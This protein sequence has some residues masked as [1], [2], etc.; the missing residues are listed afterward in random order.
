MRC[1]VRKG[2][3]KNFAKF[4]GNHLC[5][6]LWHR[7]F[8]VNFAKFLRTPFLQNTSGHLLLAFYT[9]ILNISQRQAVSKLIEKK[10]NDKRYLKNWRP[11]SLLNVDTKIFSKA[12]SNKLKAVLPTLISSQQTAHVK[13][14]F[15][16]E[17]NR[18]IPDIIEISG[19]LN[20]E[21]F[22]V[23]MDIEKTFDSLDHDFLSSVLRKFGFGKNFIAWIEIL[24]KDQL[25]CIING[26]TTT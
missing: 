12:I 24:L 6:S 2:V 20:I 15:I 13:N 1:F 26:E 7:C 18:L 25:S 23:I 8:P 21:G 4:T 17:S 10:D 9:K 19:W 11:I 14:R 3:L 22:L 16:G 5:Q